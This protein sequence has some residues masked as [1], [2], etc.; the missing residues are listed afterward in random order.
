MGFSIQKADLFSEE[1]IALIKA[2]KALMLSQSPPESSHAL[3]IEG[4]RVAEIQVWSLFEGDT[5]VGCGALKTW[6]S[7]TGE[8]KSM[9]TVSTL[10][11]K[12]LGRQML[13]HLIEEA[14]KKNLHFLKLETGSQEGFLAARKL[15]ESAGFS[16][17]GPFGDYRLDPNS[18]FMS[19]EL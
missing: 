18:V 3:L 12:G 8:I 14:R 19:L 16:Y 17:C 7:E 2:H 4:L 13:N 15:Y 11:G 9:H 10:R 6:D 5:L 1:F